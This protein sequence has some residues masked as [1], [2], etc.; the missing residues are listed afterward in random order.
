[1][2]PTN[3][4]TNRLVPAIL[5]VVPGEPRDDF[6]AIKLPVAAGVELA[7]HLR[8]LFGGQGHA[9][10]AAQARELVLVDLAR[11]VAVDVLEEELEALVVLSVGAVALTQLLV[12]A[13]KETRRLP[14]RLPV[15][16]FQ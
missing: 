5:L 4:P 11:P 16:L 15:T 9:Q 6:L 2:Q 8:D 7:E 13:A 12:D 3:Q 1:M 14:R 10:I